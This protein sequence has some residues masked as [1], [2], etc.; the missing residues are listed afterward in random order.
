MRLFARHGYDG[1]GV[2]ELSEALGVNPPSLY[3]AF[4]SK[5]GLF[6]RAV[7]LYRR[8]YESAVPAALA[9]ESRLEDA[10]AGLFAGAADAYTDDPES[11]GCMIIEGTRSA[12]DPGACTVLGEAHG[13]TRALI[14]ERIRR[15]GAPDPEILA[16][17]V[18]AILSGLSASARRGTSKEALRAIAAIAAE[19]FAARLAAAGER[20]LRR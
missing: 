8:R 12:Q 15:D 14:L 6:E 13:S 11:P 16:D 4:G 7:E 2:A 1:V 17:Y 5:R 9:A 18:L 3:A 10:I 20:T 19:G